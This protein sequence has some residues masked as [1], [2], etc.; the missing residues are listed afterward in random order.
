MSGRAGQPLLELDP[1]LAEAVPE[2]E[3]SRAAAAA[4]ATT[5]QLERGAWDAIGEYGECADWTGL[6]VIDG[7]LVRRTCCAG[8][9]VGELIGRGDLLRPWDHDGEYPVEGIETSWELLEPTLIALLDQDFAARIAPWPALTATIL[10]RIGRRARWLGLRLLISQVQG[11]EIRVLYMLW[12][13]AERWGQADDGGLLVPVG[14]SHELLGELV[15]AQR[16][17]VSNALRRLRAEGVERVAGVGWRLP[18]DTPALID[19][20]L[21]DAGA[22]ESA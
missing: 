11:I 15:G 3:R 10:A 21:R 5:R 22:S 13:L 16:P 9:A 2:H 12:H 18:G 4:T 1:L 8:E 7:Y 20:M 14:I 17:S 19:R 6:L